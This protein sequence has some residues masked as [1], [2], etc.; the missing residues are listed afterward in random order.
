MGCNRTSA[1][2]VGL[3][4]AFAL[5]AGAPSAQ[6]GTPLE[7]GFWGPAQIDG[8]SQFPIYDD[9]GV[10]IY[11]T[12]MSWAGVAP[13]RPADARNPQDP[14]YQWPAELDATIRE[15]QRYRMKVLIMLAERPAVGQRRPQPGV[16]ADRPSD[17]GDFARAAARRYPA[18][19]T[20]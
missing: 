18:C 7:K 5:G 11:Q 16:R 8:V 6:A 1:L 9:L 19:A 10:T 17:F 12:A 14:A 13:T 20:G 2:A 15:A 4:L 3:L